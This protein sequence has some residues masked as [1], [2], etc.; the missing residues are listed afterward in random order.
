[1]TNSLRRTRARWRNAG[2]LT[3]PT[4]ALATRPPSA[5]IGM[6]ASTPVKAAA[7]IAAARAATTIGTWVRAPVSSSA[8]VRDAL[9]PTG[10]PPVNA[11]AV[12]ARP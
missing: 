5:A 7:T 12:L 4:T 2:T 8:A 3:S 1:M 6:A 9:A 11:A 10:I